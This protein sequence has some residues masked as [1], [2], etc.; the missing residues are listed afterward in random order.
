MGAQ[1]AR[2]IEEIAEQVTPDAA[3]FTIMM[4]HAGI[5]GTVPHL[6]GGLTMAQLDPL[7]GQVNYLALGHVHKRLTLDGWI[8][9]PGS[10]E[11][12][13][14]EE[15]GPDWPHG[16]FDVT[17][18]PGDELEIE[19]VERSTNG[20][21]FQRIRVEVDGAESPDDVFMR[22]EA[23]VK[24]QRK[25]PAGAVVEISLTGTAPFRRQEIP[26]ERIR[27][28]A[29]T[30]FE[31]LTVRVNNLISPPGL[32]AASQSRLPRQELERQVIEKLVRQRPEYQDH[33][34]DW[35]RLILDIKNMARDGQPPA[36]IVDHLEAERRAMS[37]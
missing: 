15:T 20:R 16:F 33:A 30:T 22:V 34:D 7:K 12:C 36:S 17:V 14:L 11:T 9:N 29:L 25:V 2:V 26:V 37:E 8:F 3:G 28:L 10:T 18:R 23:K 4:L 32:V 31:P 13:S 21:P 27:D 19:V 5:Q 24:A 35:T 1:T 6:H